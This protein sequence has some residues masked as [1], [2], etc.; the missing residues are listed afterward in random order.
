MN[1]EQVK[2]KTPLPQKKKKKQK[3]RKKLGPMVQKLNPEQ[4]RKNL[5]FKK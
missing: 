3:K 2:R 5:Q 4:L 1:P